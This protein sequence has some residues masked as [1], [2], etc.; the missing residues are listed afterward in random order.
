VKDWLQV[1]MAMRWS[2][3]ATAVQAALR[4]VAQEHLR[5]AA[6]H[7]LAL[8]RHSPARGFHPAIRPGQVARLHSRLTGEDSLGPVRDSHQAI[9]RERVASVRLPARQARLYRCSPGRVR[10]SFFRLAPV[11][12][13]CNRAARYADPPT[14]DAGLELPIAED[15]H[16]KRRNRRE[17][18]GCGSKNN[19]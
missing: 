2:S 3:Q 6:K 8:A 13:K 14:L 7:C 4:P 16:Q 15:R 11:G 1:P 18:V 17:F 19:R 10:A 12:R 9:L 5:L